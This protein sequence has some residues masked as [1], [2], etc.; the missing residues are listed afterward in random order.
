MASAMPALSN[1]RQLLQVT[2]VQAEARDVVLVELKAPDGA[3]LPPFEPGA[4]LEIDLPN[5]LVRHYSLTNDWRE[6]DRYV[7]GVG[8]AA[9]G[10]GG[11]AFVHQ[12]LR[13]GMQLAVSAPRNNFALD[14]KADS[15]LFIAGGIGVTPMMAMI[16][17]CEAQSR[18]W[19][20]VYAARNCQRTAF[21]ETLRAHGER[22]HFHF[23]D[24]AGTVLDVREWLAGEGSGEHVYCCGPQPLMQAVQDHAA[25]RPASRVH[26]EYFTAPATPAAD[27]MPA[28]AF[29]VELRR[30]GK[31]LT[32]P[33]DRSILEVLEADGMNVPFSCREGLCGTC[34]TAVCEGLVEHRDYVLSQEQRDAGKSMM[35]CVSRALSPV[36]VLDL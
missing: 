27:A 4:H 10:R 33:A 2:D 14:P 23:D 21:Y 12:S 24:L 9:N 1:G 18:P 6:R 22:V 8:R 26:F 29:R 19:R 11:S 25:H 31:S 34:E 16:R 17:W 36:L 3:A 7:V 5:G 30:S 20:L 13:R 32:V 35:I 28:G 15:Y